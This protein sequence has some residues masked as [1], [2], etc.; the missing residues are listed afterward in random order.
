VLIPGFVAD[1]S[2]AW[3]SIA[4][5]VGGPTSRIDSFAAEL[6]PLRQYARKAEFSFSPRGV[7]AVV[8]RRGV[9]RIDAVRKASCRRCPT[10]TFSAAGEAYR[11]AAEE[12]PLVRL[13]P[14]NRGI[15]QRV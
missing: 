10:T 4:D 9:D 7:E 8:P 12:P 14:T 5:L 2:C 6:S 1:L 3:A 15:V 13:R 11:L